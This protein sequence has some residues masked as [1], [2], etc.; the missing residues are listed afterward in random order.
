MPINETAGKRRLLRFLLAAAA[1]VVVALTP[2]AANAV[3]NEGLFELEGNIADDAGV[4]GH[5]WSD[6][7]AGIFPGGSAPVSSAF[8][9]DG[10]N[11]VNDTIYFG[12]GSQNNNDIPS[13]KWSCGSVST[14]SDIEHAFASAYI[15]D[16]QLFLYFGADRYDPTGGTTNVGFWFLQSGGALDGGNG[17]PD[18]DP[19]TNT[20]SDQHVDGDLFVFAEF[21]GGG[22]DSAVSMYEWLNGGLHLL[23][24]KSSGSFCSADDSICALTNDQTIA[25]TWPYSDNQGGSADGQILEGGFV[26][27]GINLS[28]IYEGLGK[29]LPCVNR[30]LAQTGSSH[31]DT[32]VLEDFAGGSFNVC[33]KLIVDKVA[34]SGDQ[35]KFAFSVSGANYTDSFQ[36]ADAD[37]PH[38]SGQIKSGT[39]QVTETPGSASVWNAPSVTCKDQGGNDVPY[40]QNGSVAIAPGATV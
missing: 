36:L 16:D 22:G 3:H 15:K 21:T 30:F 26:E 8:I 12:G 25:S 39:Y 5:D 1:I 14:K 4:P 6:V 23:A 18:S 24:S 31:P 17:C 7:H 2:I 28:S 34:P 38:D 19:A 33:S 11:G 35:T 37:A 27:G 40:G 10:F 13:W 32:G 20:F 9:A 29:D